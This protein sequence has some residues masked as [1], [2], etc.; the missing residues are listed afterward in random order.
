[1][2]D[3]FS[4][5]FI[6]GTSRN[7]LAERRYARAYAFLLRA[8]ELDPSLR[9]PY[10]EL[11]RVIAMAGR[12]ADAEPLL[13]AMAVHHSNSADYW[14][15]R[16]LVA[17]ETE[18]YQEAE[19]AFAEARLH[20]S[21]E[22]WQAFNDPSAFYEPDTPEGTA[23][24][25]ASRDPRFL[26]SYNERLLIHYAR[27]VYADLRFGNMFDKYR[28]WETE[29]GQVI[30]RYG[31]PVR[32][33]N[34]QDRFD[35]AL[36]FHYDETIAFRFMD[37][38]KAGRWTFYSPP[39]SSLSGRVTFDIWKH[40][41]TLRSKELF[42]D[43]PER[44]EGDKLESIPFPYLVNQLRGADGR[45]ELWVPVGVVVETSQRTPKRGAVTLVGEGQGLVT[46][47]FELS[48]L[49]PN[50]TGRMYAQGTLFVDH[51][52]L[53]ADPG[54][55]EIAVEYEVRSAEPLVAFDRS[56]VE[57]TDYSGSELAASDL[58]LAYL[59]EE[60]YGGHSTMGSVSRH[61]Y[62]IDL[63]PW[64][65][66]GIGQPLY[67]YYELYNLGLNE[68]G[69][70]RYDVE[71]VI[72]KRTER[73]RL[74]GG[75]RDDGAVSVRTQQRITSTEVGDFLILDT[76]DQEPGLY[77]IRVEVF[78]RETGQRVEMERQIRLE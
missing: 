60:E 40:D 47:A 68:E 38:A 8:A 44:V 65:V 10:P 6:E 28:G 42:H 14:L 70:G 17:A 58:V 20:L 74:F 57:V 39:A 56:E 63:A 1:M 13:D 71:T 61:G 37:L 64:G 11:M 62:A 25:W 27:L 51:Y 21:E 30:V 75:R 36:A 29:P 32:E 73:R 46:H 23:P 9:D 52:Q 34:M 24:Y 5:V 53:S 45:T 15:Y 31:R 18:Q 78:D 26:T 4:D 55:Y 48:P 72:E 54:A 49:D 76:S 69:E 59:V 2:H 12:Y 41:M 16:G 50:L 7:E 77:S 66:F 22:E 33:V 35:R 3:V 67:L 19:M 43:Y